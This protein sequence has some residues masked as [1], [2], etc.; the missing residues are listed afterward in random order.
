MIYDIYTICIIILAVLI[1]AAAFYPILSLY[2]RRIGGPRAEGGTPPLVENGTHHDD[3][4]FP[5]VSVGDGKKAENYSPDEDE[6][7]LI[8][9]C[10]SGSEE[11]GVL[12]SGT[13][14]DYSILLSG[15]APRQKLRDSIVSLMHSHM[16]FT[17][18]NG[19]LLSLDDVLSDAGSA[20]EVAGDSDS[21]YVDPEPPRQREARIDE[22]IRRLENNKI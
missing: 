10:V 1:I 9:E 13:D 2:F 20:E 19:N 6:L 3:V 16:Q 5:M 8:E 14:S 12:D 4:T 15:N 17:D 21:R 22:A 7:D 11:S 18:L